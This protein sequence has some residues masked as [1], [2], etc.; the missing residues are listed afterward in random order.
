[1]SR[2]RRLLMAGGAVVLLGVAG[3]AWFLWPS[4]LTPTPAITL[5]NFRLLR[6]GM[7]LKDVE[8]WL[9]KPEEA[10]GPTSNTLPARSSTLSGVLHWRNGNLW[11]GLQF[12]A[13]RLWNGHA[14]LIDN[15]YAAGESLAPPVESL[16]DRIR[17]WLH[18]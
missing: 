17:R 11:I 2:R 14:G 10:S 4:S 3:L 13:G 1:M 6:K 15:P 16:L 18:L 9:G 5:A 7:S 12:Q 8:A